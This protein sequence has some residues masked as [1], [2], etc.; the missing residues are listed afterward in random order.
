[1][2][3]LTTGGVPASLE[4]NQRLGVTAPADAADPHVQGVEPDTLLRTGTIPGS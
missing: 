3:N 2:L 1:M 4:F